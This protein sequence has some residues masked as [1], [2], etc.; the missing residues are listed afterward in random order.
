MN[1]TSNQLIIVFIIDNKYIINSFIESIDKFWLSQNESLAV[2]DNL[3]DFI[4]ASWILFI[5][6]LSLSQTIFISHP[7]TSSQNQIFPKE[8]NNQIK[9]IRYNTIF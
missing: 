1:N 7:F 9:I 3:S 6:I 8:K 4:D 5:Q 2:I